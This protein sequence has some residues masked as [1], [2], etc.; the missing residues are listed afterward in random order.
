MPRVPISGA[1]ATPEFESFLW[2][3]MLG[4]KSAARSLT[5]PASAGKLERIHNQLQQRSSQDRPRPR[6][7]SQ[8]AMS[9]L[10]RPEVVGDAVP[11]RRIRRAQ[12]ACYRCHDKK[13][14]ELLLYIRPQCAQTQ[15]KHSHMAQIKCDLQLN[16]RQGTHQSCQN[17]I[18]AEEECQ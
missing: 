12:M 6:G 5:H 15:E 11:K 9:L 13:V 17:C 8:A 7:H 4:T 16:R 2:S 3:V 18:D 1:P 10:A 14:S